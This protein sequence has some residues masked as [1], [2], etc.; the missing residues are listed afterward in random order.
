MTPDHYLVDILENRMTSYPPDTHLVLDPSPSLLEKRAKGVTGF[1]LRSSIALDSPVT[2]ISFCPKMKTFAYG[3]ED[4]AFGYSPS[5]NNGAIEVGHLKATVTKVAQYPEKNMI[6]ASTLDNRLVVFE[7]CQDSVDP[8]LVKTFDWPVL[9][10]AWYKDFIVAS[11]EEQTV[12]LFDLKGDLIESLDRMANDVVANDEFIYLADEK[13]LAAYRHGTR[14]EMVWFMEIDSQITSLYLSDDGKTLAAD[15]S[16]T[17]AIVDAKTGQLLNQITVRTSSPGHIIRSCLASNFLVR[18]YFDPIEDSCPTA[19]VWSWR[20]G[21]L[22]ARIQVAEET[23]VSAAWDHEN[24]IL[25]LASDDH[26]VYFL[27][28]E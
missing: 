18:G 4:G 9:A 14:L 23:I 19:Y 16:E 6:A 27:E 3:T 8:L 21:Q 26:H 15:T 2:H 12:K 17:T 10:C 24:M 28:P 7:N 22:I 20:T 1:C 13:T 25:A 5:L 11:S